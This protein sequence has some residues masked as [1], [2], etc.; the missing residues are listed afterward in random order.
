MKNQ[1]LHL[2]I[3]GVKGHIFIFADSILSRGTVRLLQKQEF[4]VSIPPRQTFEFQTEEVESTYD[5]TGAKFGYKYSG[6][7]LLLRDRS[8]KTV[9]EKSTSATLLH[10]LE[11]FADLEIGSDYDKSTWAPRKT[12]P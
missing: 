12:R 10:H 1:E 4:D 6:W 3:E 2:P 8:G 9:F 5:T 7:V 11:K